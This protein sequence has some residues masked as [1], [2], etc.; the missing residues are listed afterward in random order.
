M[1]WLTY[2]GMEDGTGHQSEGGSD[3]IGPVLD[4]PGIGM[5]EALRVRTEMVRRSGLVTL[6]TQRQFAFVGECFGIAALV[7]SNPLE[8][9]VE[10]TAA[11]ELRR[12]AP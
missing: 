3:A 2:H 11:A 1:P 8:T 6:T 10:F 4:W 7:V 9:Q 5:I 12:L